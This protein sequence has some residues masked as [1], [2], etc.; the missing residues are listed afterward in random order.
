MELIS[1]FSN[2]QYTWVYCDSLISNEIRLCDHNLSAGCC[3]VD[4][5]MLNDAGMPRFESC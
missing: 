3:T 2:Y 5:D 1:S 4:L